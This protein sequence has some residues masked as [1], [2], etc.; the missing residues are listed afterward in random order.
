MAEHLNTDA[1][2]GA[3]REEGIWFLAL[4]TIL[5]HLPLPASTR[6]TSAMVPVLFGHS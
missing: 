6:L 5:S 1:D 3:G 4:S 2:A